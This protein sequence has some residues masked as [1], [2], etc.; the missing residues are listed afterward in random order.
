MVPTGN[1]GDAL[2]CYV[3]AQSGLLESFS[4]TAA[5]NANDAMARLLEGKPLTRG[6]T[7]ATISPAMDIQLP[8]NFE[9]L[10]FEATSADGKPGG[11]DGAVVA[12]TYA[13]LASRGSGAI[14]AEVAKRLGS[15]GLSAERV[16][17]DQTRKEM[18]RTLA[19]TGWIVCPHTAVGLAAA[20]RVTN[21]DG[22]IV[23]LGT[24][25][26]AKFP[27]TAKDVLGIDIGLPD[28]A[29]PFVSRPEKFE[30]GPMSADHVRKRIEQ[31]IAK[32]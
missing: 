30:T 31:L 6:E 7:A 4:A 32:G 2:A 25:H 12:K 21:A 26:A 18:K 11:R 17:D 9:R 29:S 14:P 20:R 5:V 1:F 22:P 19:E 3:A 28:R 16:S 23:T 15:M 24:A 10:F 13:E 27:E 8:S